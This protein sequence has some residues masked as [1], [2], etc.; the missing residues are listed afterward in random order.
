MTDSAVK[1]WVN[2]LAKFSLNCCSCFRSCPKEQRASW[3]IKEVSN[4]ADSR[5]YF[6]AHK[7]SLLFSS[8]SNNKA[9]N[10]DSGSTISDYRKQEISS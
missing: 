1:R 7:E 2:I 6:S 4:L 10:I 3:K 8:G 5:A 9:G